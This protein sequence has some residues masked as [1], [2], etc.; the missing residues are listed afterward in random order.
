M[1]QILNIT[2]YIKK[3]SF[4]NILVKKIKTILLYF[5]VLRNRLN[6]IELQKICFFYL[7][8]VPDFGGDFTYIKLGKKE[9]IIN[10]ENYSVIFE[11]DLSE[12]ISK[13]NEHFMD[14]SGLYALYMNDIIKKDYMM[15]IHYDTQIRH[16]KWLEII[17][18]KVKNSNVIYSTWDIDREHS[19][20]AKWVYC[21]IDKVFLSTHHRTFLSFLKENGFHRLPN[22]SQFACRKET[23]VKLM[24]FLMPI[25][26]Y[27]L[28]EKKLTFKYAHL[29]ER[30]WGLFFA[31]ENY[32]I[33]SV[34]RDTHSQSF[35]DPSNVIIIPLLTT[36][37]N[38]KV[39]TFS[40]LFTD[41][42]EPL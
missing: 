40:E 41:N 2:K 28:A 31:L 39:E 7:P 9:R 38:K 29:L 32:K 13:H 3:K 15:V 23:F 19:E 42:I 14:Y 10:P 5:Y 12:N 4:I 24:Q 22:S 11:A 25:Y 30:A 20:V 21:H 17:Q 37:I 35:S 1:S 26:E 27:I 36:A 6:P 8:E 16:E 18:A 34:I 33:V